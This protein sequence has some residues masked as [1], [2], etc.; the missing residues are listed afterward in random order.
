V[1]P[2]SSAAQLF[3]RLQYGVLDQADHGALHR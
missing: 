1:I 2:T 3:E